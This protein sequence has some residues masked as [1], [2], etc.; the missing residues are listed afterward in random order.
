MDY[1]AAAKKVYGKHVRPLTVKKMIDAPKIQ[2]EIFM[3]LRDLLNKTGT[4]P[5]YTLGK[6]KEFLEAEEFPSELKVDLLKTLMYVQGLPLKEHAEHHQ[7]NSR[8]KYIEGFL[9][10]LEDGEDE[11]KKALPDEI[12]KELDDEQD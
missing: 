10:Q 12:V 7:K 8:Q 1:F 9:A 5:E 3:N 2:K 6:L 4:T 11:E